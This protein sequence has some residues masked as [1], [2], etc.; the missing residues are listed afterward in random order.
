MT[1]RISGLLV[2]RTVDAPSGWSPRGI[3]FDGAYLWVANVRTTNTEIN[4]IG[5]IDITK[6]N[7]KVVRTVDVGYFP[8]GVTFDG[9]YLW[10]ANY[11]SKRISKIDVTTNKVVAEIS[12]GTRPF[13]VA[14]DGTHLWVTNIESKDI[15]KILI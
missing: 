13:G 11:Y 1:A 5:K 15:N 6:D 8:M 14:F 12:V 9:A 3:A 10:V 4:L 2:V 7:E